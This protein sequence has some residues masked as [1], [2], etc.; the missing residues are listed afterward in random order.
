MRH[1]S[2]IVAFAILVP[3]SNCLQPQPGAQ[4]RGAASARAAEPTGV[5]AFDSE[6]DGPWDIYLVNPDGSNLWRLTT[7][8]HDTE[9]WEPKSSPNG[10]K[11]LFAS[12]RHGGQD[13]VY[14]M[15]ADGSNPRHLT[16]T[17]GESR[18]SWSADWS[19]DGKRIVFHSN[20]DAEAE[21]W[22]GY[23]LYVME[24]DGANVRRLTPS[25]G[26]PA[27]SPDGKKIAFTGITD[28]H[29]EI[30]VVDADGSDVRRLT[31]DNRA[32]VRA[33]WSPDGKRIAFGSSRLASADRAN[34]DEESDIYVMDS[35]GSNVRRLTFTPDH[36]GH[37]AWSSDGRWIAFSS[38]RDGR[39]G[40]FVMRANG[41]DLRRVTSSGTFEGHPNWA[42]HNRSGRSSSANVPTAQGARGEGYQQQPLGSD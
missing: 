13:E 38:Q 9:S 30:F 21:G 42:P 32:A 41:S 12:N 6:R 31:H 39:Y 7:S 20:R 29:R 8:G 15:D 34:E 19:P 16:H 10:R 28:G 14:V 1:A 36:D 3:Q 4:Q 37:P 26:T 5:I 2:A 25:G 27:W 33:A 11:I 24:A 18:S 40:I 35:D 17:P 22:R 23:G